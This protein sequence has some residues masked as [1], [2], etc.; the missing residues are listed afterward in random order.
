MVFKQWSPL[1]ATD[2]V[3]N[4]PPN[5]PPPNMVGVSSYRFH[6]HYVNFPMISVVERLICYILNKLKF[7]DVLF[8]AH[9]EML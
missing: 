2:S 3:T 8:T 4:Q 7:R 1:H 5:P 9:V 6:L